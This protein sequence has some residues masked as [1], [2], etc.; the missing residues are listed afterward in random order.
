MAR[1]NEEP[2]LLVPDIIVNFNLLASWLLITSWKKLGID[3]YIVSPGYRDAPLLA[4]LQAE[5]GLTTISAFDERAAAYQALGYGKATGKPAVLVCTSGTAG[6]N[7]YPAVIEAAVEQVPLLVLTADRPFELVHAGAQQVID[8]RALFGRFVKQSFDFP[9][10]SPTM[11]LQAWTSYAREALR[12]TQEGAAGPVH[13]NV[14]FGSPLDPLADRGEELS[15]ARK[16]LA[17]LWQG[18]DR[19]VMTSVQ[20]KLNEWAAESL[21]KDLCSAKRGLLI[22]GRLSNAEEQASALAFAE[23]LAW[24]VYADISSGCKGRLSREILDAAHPA[25]RA[26]LDTYQPDCV[27][28]VG[29]RLVSRAFDDALEAWNP[30]SYWVLSEE[31]GIQDPAHLPQRMQLMLG[32]SSLHQFRSS[33]RPQSPSSEQG[34]LLTAMK[35]L[36]AAMREMKFAD[37]GFAAVAGT[38]NAAMKEFKQGLFLGNS[39]AIRAFD[40]WVYDPIYP[41][42]CEANRGVSGIEGL[43]ATTMGLAVGSEHPW[44]LLIGDVSLMHD[45]NSLLLLAQQRLPVIIVLVNNQGGRIFE[46]L[47]IRRHAWVKDPLMTT[48]HGFHFEG[49]AS[50]A[51]ISYKLCSD[52]SQLQD[53]Y[54]KAL[55]E[56][57]PA[58]IECLQTADVDA[59]YSQELRKIT[60][61]KESL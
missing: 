39:L 28:H 5:A 49:L 7:Y 35:G 14:P 16:T 26:C 41:V 43:L 56:G 58:L 20:P 51:G 12:L 52:N 47:S 18:W 32:P 50:M 57:G 38:V 1:E 44:T 48:P 6:A 10:P 29:R 17:R 55:I 37:F 25:A 13:L 21:L 33:L 45:L 36:R 30:E 53:A 24:P 59:R 42:V 34:A 23:D 31:A 11:S 19:Q 61:T 40:S 2:T 60:I 3:T 54:T 4:V 22:L 46:T 8:Q 27:V 9:C 15:K